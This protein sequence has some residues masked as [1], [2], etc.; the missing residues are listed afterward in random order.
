MEIVPGARDLNLANPGH[1]RALDQLAKLTIR[2]FGLL[3]DKSSGDTLLGIAPTLASLLIACGTPTYPIM[4]RSDV[5]RKTKG[6][7]ED[8]VEYYK[9]LL[10]DLEMTKAISNRKTGEE[11]SLRLKRNDG[12][13]D[14]NLI[15]IPPTENNPVLG[16]SAEIQRRIETERTQAFLIEDN[17]GIT[18]APN[19]MLEAIS[20]LRSG[21]LFSSL[22]K[23][24]H[25]SLTLFL[26]SRGL[27]VTNPLNYT[28]AYFDSE[29][30][31][32]LAITEFFLYLAG[33]RVVKDVTFNEVSPK[34]SDK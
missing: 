28:N 1:P 13:V 27:N 29:P 5:L 10:S 33:S 26:E 20:R 30:D 2:E 3:P 21:G 11:F 7:P 15:V 18:I 14:R 25:I 17:A 24:T 19:P 34:P 23:P 6:D 8:M 22:L 4:A 31:K 16:L 9:Y 12:S 32:D